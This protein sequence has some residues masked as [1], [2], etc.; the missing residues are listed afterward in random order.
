MLPQLLCQIVIVQ[1]ACSRI[2]G[3]EYKVENEQNE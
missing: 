1:C 2:V 3:I